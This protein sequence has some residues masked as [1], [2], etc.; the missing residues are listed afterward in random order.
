MIY[1]CTVLVN[2]IFNIVLRESDLE[3]RDRLEVAMD[4]AQVE[5]RRGTSG[6][7][8]QMRQP[9]LRGIV[10][11]GEW[12]AYPEVEHIHNYSWYIGNYPALKT[13]KVLELCGMLNNA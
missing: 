8:N 11:E 5:Y 13:E 9:Y 6:G 3:L 10:K 1:P 4:K 2:L 12:E 7:G